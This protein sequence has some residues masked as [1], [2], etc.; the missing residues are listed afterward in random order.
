MFVIYATPIMESFKGSKALSIYNKEYPDVFEKK[1]AN[2]L[3]QCFPYNCL[4]DL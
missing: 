2:I 1:N 3:S 4:I